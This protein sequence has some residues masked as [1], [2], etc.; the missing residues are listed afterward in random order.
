MKKKL[1]AG[2]AIGLFLA[3]MGV[4]AQATLIQFDF[5][6]YVTNSVMVTGPNQGQPLP[7][8]PIANTQISGHYIFESTSA[9]LY[10]GETYS[11]YENLTAFIMNVGTLTYTFTG[12]NKYARGYIQTQNN[13]GHN[14]TD[15]YTV[16]V[17]GGEGFVGSGATIGAFRIVDFNMMLSDWGNGIEPDLLLD[18]ALPL[19]PPDLGLLTNL[20][21]Y[22]TDITT[23]FMFSYDDGGVVSTQGQLHGVVTSLTAPVPEPTTLLLLS[24]GF[25]SLVGLRRR[26]RRA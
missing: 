3:V 1:L 20:S 18:D 7:G 15:R 22:G 14:L 26:S 19:L 13:A 23:Q 2:L 6:G 21:N 10:A 25:L 9:D 24:S 12:P 17:T 8:A 11:H 4:T 16:T 5:E